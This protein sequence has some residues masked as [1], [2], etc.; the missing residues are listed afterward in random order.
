MFAR[1]IALFAILAVAFGS[2]DSK[3][4]SASVKDTSVNGVDGLNIKWTAPFKFQDYVVGFRTTLGDLRRAP[5]ELFAKRS[6]N[7]GSDGTATVDADYTISSKRLNFNGKWNNDKLELNAEGNSDDKL[8]SISAT[9]HQ[10]LNGNN[11]DIGAAYD[12]LKK[13]VTG[14]TELQVDDTT[15][16]VEYDN[17]DRNPVLSVSHKLDD[18]NTVE[19]SIALKSGDMTYG[20][21][22]NINGG[23]LG[24]RLHPGDKVD[25]TWED[26]GANGVWTTKAEVPLENTQNTKVSFSRDWAY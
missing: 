13:R 19:P 20:W 10:K 1:L 15:V 2:S 14:N 3:S 12:L 23:K 16:G 25:I 24:T 8:T 21:V 4:V 17:A 11:W 6:F 22:R 5:D 7:L 9:T 26:N 18:R